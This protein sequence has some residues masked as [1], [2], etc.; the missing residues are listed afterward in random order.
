MPS[1]RRSG[2]VLMKCRLH[3]MVIYVLKIPTNIGMELRSTLNTTI[4]ELPEFE[5]TIKYQMAKTWN[6][7]PFELR[8]CHKIETFKR[9]LKT[10]YFSIDYPD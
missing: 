8:N 7:L 3:L 1:A 5:N 2:G 4:L 10:H 9:Q 6:S